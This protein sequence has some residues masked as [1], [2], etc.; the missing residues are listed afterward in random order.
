MKPWRC[1]D[2]GR[3]KPA[4]DFSKRRDGR[5][6]SYCKPCANTRWQRYRG[7]GAGSVKRAAAMHVPG[8]GNSLC[9]IADVPR[10]RYL[11]PNTEA[12]PRRKAA[13]A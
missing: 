11:T 10:E 13:S 12:K 8:A 4:A 9:G 1:A 7:A 2:C 3:E 5:P 6:I